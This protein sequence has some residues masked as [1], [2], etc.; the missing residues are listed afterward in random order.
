LKIK[1]NR[2]VRLSLKIHLGN[3]TNSEGK[4]NGEIDIT[5]LNSYKITKGI[6]WNKDMT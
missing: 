6:L 3:K 4:M 5:V 1:K 2:T